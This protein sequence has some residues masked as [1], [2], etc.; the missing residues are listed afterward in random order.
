ML[1]GKIHV[2]LGKVF[3]QGCSR[4]TFGSLATISRPS[5]LCIGCSIRIRY[6]IIVTQSQAGFNQSALLVLADV[7]SKVLLFAEPV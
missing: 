6:T 4:I 2:A 3:E 1:S 5:V 7:A